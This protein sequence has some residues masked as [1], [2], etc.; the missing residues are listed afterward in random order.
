L[1]IAAP[2]SVSETSTQGGL[3]A[4]VAGGLR[5]IRIFFFGYLVA[6]GFP[7]R[8]DVLGRLST[9]FETVKVLLF[10]LSLRISEVCTLRPFGEIEKHKNIFKGQ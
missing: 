6:I 1:A 7:N 4:G 9:H 3:G 8:N 2:A 5:H 10:H